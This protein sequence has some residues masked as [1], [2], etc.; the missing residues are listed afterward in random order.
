MSNIFFPLPPWR[1]GCNCILGMKETK[2]ETVLTLYKNESE[3]NYLPMW[4]GGKVI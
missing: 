2:W 4:R 3:T 1:K